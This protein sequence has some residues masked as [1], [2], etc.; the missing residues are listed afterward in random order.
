MYDILLSDCTSDLDE[1]EDSLGNDAIKSK[2][3]NMRSLDPSTIGDDD[4][5]DYEDDDNDYRLP[6]RK[7][8]YLK[9][10]ANFSE[11]NNNDWDS[12]SSMTP[13]VSSVNLRNPK[14]VRFNEGDSNSNNVE[15]LISSANEFNEY[16]FKNIASFKT[17]S[18]DFLFNPKGDISRNASSSKLS[19]LGS[20]FALSEEESEDDEDDGVDVFVRGN[21]ISRMSTPKPMK[22]DE[23]NNDFETFERELMESI[24]SLVI[25]ADYSSTGD[26]TDEVSVSSH[27]EITTDDAMSLFTNLIARLLRE[28]QEREGSLHVEPKMEVYKMHSIPSLTYR[29]FLNR[30]QSK[31][32]FRSTIYVASCYLLQ[33][34]FLDDS[35]NL[36]SKFDEISVHRII[37]AVIRLSSKL[38]EDKVH[39]HEYFSKVAGISRKLLT[40]LELT[41][42]LLLQDDRLIMTGRKLVNTI[43]TLKHSCLQ[44]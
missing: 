31:C 1:N 15:N 26:L 43:K 18:N 5:E 11:L 37:I 28:S 7:S 29:S 8:S 2:M 20:N 23:D 6:I 12:I 9:L 41:L 36:K 42:L 14:S 30:V 25:S 38:I 35:Q 27:L 32:E 39:S 22:R 21:I 33:Q 17:L 34:L 44:D 40:S 10:S 16:L 19:Q 13:N 3:L 24:S 4:N